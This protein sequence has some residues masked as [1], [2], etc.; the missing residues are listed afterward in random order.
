MNKSAKYSVGKLFAKYD[1]YLI[2]FIFIVVS[3][4]LS[5][6]FL[7]VVNI[8][9]ILKQNAAVGIV[10]LGEF[11]VILTGGID[12]SVGGIT[13]MS[14]IICALLLKMGIVWPAAVLVAIILGILAGLINGSFIAFFKMVP[15]VVTLA[16]YNIFAGIALLVSKGRQVFYTND[17][18]L[19]IST[20]TYWLFPLIAIIWFAIAFITHF[21]L[22]KTPTGRYI[23]GIGGN[24]EA[25]RLSGVSV[26]YM[27]ILAYVF[28]GMMAAVGG[29]IMASRMTLGSNSVGDGWELTAI[30]SVMIG[31][32][33]PTGG[34]GRV[35]GVIVGTLV[36]G[37][38]V[39]I[40]NLVGISIYWQQIIKGIIIIVAVFTN[41]LR[42]IKEKK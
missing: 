2:L 23:R 3:T 40:M 39:N 41:S 27:E 24:R 7:T 30:A 19:K 5:T 14:C 26:K 37:L 29:V 38:I 6:K 33:S 17:L 21:M 9:N 15:F 28:A 42:D 12:L 22:N 1:R 32:A 20:D 35:G 34:I 25:V 8:S 11:I 18:F 36:M 10:A 31:G 16:T 4:L 13:S